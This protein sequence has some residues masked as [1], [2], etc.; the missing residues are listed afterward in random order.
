MHIH[1]TTRMNMAY[2]PPNK[3]TTLK[4]RHYENDYPTLCETTKQTPVEGGSL[5]YACA[6][7]TEEPKQEETEQVEPGW[8]K[9]N[10]CRATG[11][12]I[13]TGEPATNIWDTEER[14]RGIALKNLVSKWQRERDEMTDVLDQYSPYWGMKSLEAPLSDDDLSDSDVE[15]ESE[16]ESELESDWS[17]FADE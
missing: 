10:R 1:T 12:V 11:K 9:L 6:V 13:R 4:A 14:R 15:L 5:H 17:D 7:K 3:R 16:S 2:V 8:V